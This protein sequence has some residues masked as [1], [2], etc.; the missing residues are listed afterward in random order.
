MYYVYLLRSESHPNQR[1]IGLTDDL[2]RR[3]EHHNRAS[4]PHTAKFCPWLLVTY[5][6]FS[7]KNRAVVFERYL[8]SG[9]G[10]AF[11]KTPPLLKLLRASQGF[12]RLR[13]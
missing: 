4:S 1:Y 7:A 5:I 8:K 13:L 2:R 12:T 11:A 6:A 3:V 9:S 10:R